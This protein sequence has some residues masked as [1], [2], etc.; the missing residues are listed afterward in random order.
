MHII[1][2]HSP[3]LFPCHDARPTKARA[4]GFS[5]TTLQKWI[6]SLNEK[7]VGNLVY[8]YEERQRIPTSTTE[9]AISRVFH[10]IYFSKIKFAHRPRRH[11]LYRA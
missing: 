10:I 9:E 5:N 6:S 8:R 11:R 4:I 7:D 1:L 3:Q 2:S